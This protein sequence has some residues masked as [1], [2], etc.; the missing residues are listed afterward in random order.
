MQNQR[1]HKK[2]IEFTGFLCKAQEDTII[3]QKTIIVHSLLRA[4][5]SAMWPV[6]GFPLIPE[7]ANKLATG[8][9]KRLTRI[10]GGPI[11]PDKGV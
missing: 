1:L 5:L 4:A 8:H 9:E 7:T 2:G 11:Y 3:G 10:V 6:W